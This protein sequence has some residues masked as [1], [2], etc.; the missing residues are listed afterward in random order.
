MRQ[1]VTAMKNITEKYKKEIN[2]SLLCYDRILIKGIVPELNYA[3]RDLSTA[4]EFA[5]PETIM[6]SEASKK[7]I[8]CKN[9]KTLILFVIRVLAF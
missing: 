5:E 3:C 7:E 6:Y 8:T 4:N 9:K 2:F 1:K